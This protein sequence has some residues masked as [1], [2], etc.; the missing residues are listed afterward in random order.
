MSNEKIPYLCGGVIFTLLKQAAQSS[1]SSK[2]HLKGMSDSHSN[3]NM[4][5]DLIIAL[6]ADD[7]MAVKQPSPK[8]VSKY[9]NCME[10]V[11]DGLPFAQGVFVSSYSA[12]VKSKYAE[13]LEK[14]RIFVLDHLDPNYYEWLVK[15]VLYVIDKDSDIDDSDQFFIAEDGTLKTK[16]EIRVMNDFCLPAVLVGV[17]HYVLLNRAKTNTAGKSTLDSWSKQESSRKRTYMREKWPTFERKIN[18]SLEWHQPEPDVAVQETGILAGSSVVLKE[19]ISKIDENMYEYF[20]SDTQ[21]IL[22]YVITHDPSSEPIDGLLPYNLAQLTKNWNRLVPK[23]ENREMNET[24]SHILDLLNQ[25][26]QFISDEFLRVVEDQNFLIFRNQS[27]EERRKLEGILRP[28][29]NEIRHALRQR[30]RRLYN[31][32]EIDQE[33]IDMILPEEEEPPRS[34]FQDPPE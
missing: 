19:S 9:V 25:Y 18:V 13:A 34:A 14:M 27:V 26:R 5:K 6:R 31:I 28:K 24:V 7:T 30:Y 17:M 15:L 10:N 3:P 32:P 8:V 33:F 20:K 21:D 12:L 11:P 22:K 1:V 16:A 4:M 2:E 29:T 23:I